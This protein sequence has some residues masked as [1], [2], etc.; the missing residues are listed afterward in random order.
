[1]KKKLVSVLLAAVMTVSSVSVASA[2]SMDPV[3]ESF[4]NEELTTETENE[5]ETELQETETQESESSV[6]SV[7]DTGDDVL[8]DGST[9]SKDNLISDPDATQTESETQPAEDSQKNVTVKAEK[10]DVFFASDLKKLKDGTLEDPD[11]KTDSLAD[12]T[13]ETETETES[14]EE[15]DKRT[16]AIKAAE[17]VLPEEYSSLLSDDSY[18]LLMKQKH[19]FQVSD[20]VDFYVVP[21]EGYDVDHVKVSSSLYGELQVTDYENGVYEVSM[22]DDDITIETKAVEHTEVEIESEEETESEET[23][24][25]TESE[26]EKTECTCLSDS[27]NGYD[28]DW[29]CP[30]F[31]EQFKEDCTCGNDE[32]KVTSHDYNCE[33]FIKAIAAV[34][35][36][37]VGD[38]YPCMHDDCEVIS[39][40][41]RELCDCGKDYT[42]ID[43]IIST[44]EADSAIITYLMAWNDYCNEPTTTAAPPLSPVAPGTAMSTNYALSFRFTP[45]LTQFSYGH[46]AINSSTADA[47]AYRNFNNLKSICDDAGKRFPNSGVAF[48]LTNNDNRNTSLSGKTSYWARYTNVCKI[49][50]QWYDLKIFSQYWQGAYKH[51]YDF[52]NG[53]PSQN[54]RGTLVY[55]ADGNKIGVYVINCRRI[56]LQYWLMKSGTNEGSGVN[57]HLTFA[58]VDDD[59]AIIFKKDEG[60]PTAAYYAN[61]G[62]LSIKDDGTFTG[63]KASGYDS[64]DR[65]SNNWVQ[66]DFTTGFSSWFECNASYVVNKSDNYLAYVATTAN[67]L[68]YYEDPA[69]NKYVY[70]VV[71]GQN[72]LGGRHSTAQGGDNLDTQ[73]LKVNEG[74]TVLYEIAQHVYPNQNTYL[75]F[76]DSFDPCLNITGYGV[77]N[78]EWQNVT[79]SFNWRN[80]GNR[81]IA[82]KTLT[83]EESNCHTFHLLVY[84]TVKSNR[85]LYNH[86]HS[87]SANW[88]LSN[89]ALV[90][91]TS[92][93]HGDHRNVTNQ[94]WIWGQ[95]W[96]NYNVKKVDSKTGANLTGAEFHVYQAWDEN[97]SG[98][99]DLGTLTYNASSQCYTT[100]NICF[101]KNGNMGWFK[102]VETKAPAGYSGGWDSGPFEL[103]DT[104]SGTTFTAK[105]TANAKGNLKVIKKFGDEE[106]WVESLL[107][108]YDNKDLDVSFQLF[109]TGDNGTSVNKTLKLNGSGSVTFKDIPVGTY[110]LKEIYDSE[111]WESSAVTQKVTI[112]GD[113]TVEVKVKNTFIPDKTPQPAPEKSLNT[114]SGK[115]KL[116]E[117]TVRKRSEEI[118]FSIFQ[119]IKASKH[120]VVAPYKMEIEDSIDSA[121]EYKGFKAYLSEN[122]GTSWA[123]DTGS[124]KDASSGN[125]FSISKE[126]YYMDTAAWY[127]I[128][129]TVKIKDRAH[130]DNYVQNINGTNMY[131]IP[132]KASDTLYY[133]FGED[134]VTQKTNEVKVLMPLDELSIVVKKSN[135]VTGENIP[136]AEFTVYEW[137]GTA[138]KDSVGK[139]QYSKD[140]E[141]YIIKN[142][143]KTDTNQGKFKIVETVTPWGHVGSWSK[144][145]VD[146]TNATE[147]Y[148]ATNPMGMG[149][150]TVLKKGKHE[151]VLAGAVYSIKAKENIV[152]P[153]GKVLVTAGTEVDKVTTGKDG[154][155]K[156]K[157]LYPGRYTVTETNAPLGYA[158]NKVPQDVEVTYKDKDTKVTNSSVTF[159]NNRLYSTITVTKQIDTADIVWEHGNPTFTFK[160]DGKDVLG[161]AHTY[162]KT[163]EFTKD[164]VGSG[165]KASLSAK[166]TV[167]AGTYTVSEEKTA[168]YKFGS[169]T[170]VVN[171]TISGQ[172][173]VL[174]VSGKKDGTVTEGADGA[175]TFYNVKAT[176]EDLTH[177]A[178][179]DNTIA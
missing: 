165:A 77:Y 136:N 130:L 58:D 7:P 169:I 78:N 176:D 88:N 45:G 89:Q 129:I 141:D 114:S 27:E 18:K 70:K 152:S 82:E 126:K 175:A 34:C 142:L 56:K 103:L 71:N 177:T 155:A 46:E 148:T 150:I 38:E 90:W 79:G 32:E 81:I 128:D 94:S 72:T 28:H 25:E 178:F 20:Y 87:A 51:I 132:N 91:T 14:Q 149:T 101:D 113:K 134:E 52:K 69:P 22:P 123:D 164:N 154:T 63:I 62:R 1:M 6:E 171:G 153:Q 23:E 111:I 127:R 48:A 172:T 106:G 86:G 166:F 15:K 26:S 64:I 13:T 35:T 160:V 39:R 116:T 146:G 16:A 11:L 144:E 40:M 74:D 162:Y 168:R 112:E 49:G 8:S 50:N 125:K 93:Y 24:S 57:A 54:V 3:A 121:F 95:H 37:E 12:S 44:H 110:T 147:T 73:A 119:Q 137:N 135:E 17:K 2:T 31:W 84:A 161:N 29:D 138:Y 65:D 120:P 19:S 170:D 67:T 85:T 158:L 68:G 118:T 173:A 99:T 41:H 115:N 21:E 107:A 156:S 42:V 80:S 104:P 143:K 108:D 98:W 100:P 61:T 174:D 117:K 97:L 151:E 47:G 124:F 60:G 131:V 53:S 157:E 55:S 179:V 36:C 140:R 43:D 5:T 139:M 59:Q 33:A 109:G 102:I 4:D 9:S 145:V 163:L 10:A 105:N 75:A 92:T 96:G 122:A 167:L 133:D 30:V 66:I 159:V 76:D 83:E